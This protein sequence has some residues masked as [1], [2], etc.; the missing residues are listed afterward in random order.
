MRLIL[1]GPP[2]AGKGTQAAAL[3]DQYSIVHIST[4][5]IFRANV[6]NATALGR[7]A[8]EYMDRGDLVPD[9]VVI[10][11]VDDRLKQDDARDGFLL[12]GFPRTLPQVEA[13]DEMLARNGH[14]LDGVVRLL[15]DDDELMA[16][17]LQR[18]RE[19]GRADDTREVIANRIETYKDETEPAV[20]RYRERGILYDVDGQGD[21]DEVRRRVLAAGEQA[22]QS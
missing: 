9:E 3:C 14:G 21:V 15:V 12:D 16:R 22:E 5:D 20:A 11:M 18:A 19:Q 2:G 10:A 4:G 17:L 6:G 7:R 8:S 1:F 13:L